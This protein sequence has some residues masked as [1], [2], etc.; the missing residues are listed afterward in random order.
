MSV[1]QI[2]QAAL[3][4]A[5]GFAVTYFRWPGLPT[6]QVLIPLTFGLAAGISLGRARRPAG[7]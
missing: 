2:L 3:F 4:L 5:V 1:K 6:L 7:A